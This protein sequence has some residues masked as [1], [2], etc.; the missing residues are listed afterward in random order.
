MDKSIHERA[1]GSG[2]LMQITDFFYVP[3]HVCLE[4]SR[5]GAPTQRGQSPREHSQKLRFQQT[6]LIKNTGP[7]SSYLEVLTHVIWGGSEYLPERREGAGGSPFKKCTGE[8]WRQHIIRQAG[9]KGISSFWAVLAP[10][11]RRDSV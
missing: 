3:L 5:S 1:T 9:G 7:I 11:K 10:F 2:S 6:F 4:I 8:G